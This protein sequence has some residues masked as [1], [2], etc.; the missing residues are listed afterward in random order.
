MKIA[1]IQHNPLIGAFEKNLQTILSWIDK[2]R[3]AG[4][5]LVVLPELT[6]CG[7]PPQDL[8]ERASF[9]ENHDRC[10]TEF[11]QETVDLTC[12]IGV[13][14][15]RMGPGKPLYNSAFV[16]Y[17]GAVLH[18]ARKQLLPTYDVFDET[19]YFEPGRDSL[20]FP[21]QGKLLG[22][23]ICED[24][25]CG[26]PSY[27]VNPLKGFI[28][29]PLVPDLLINISASPYFDGKICQR[30][31][32][33][34]EICGQNTLPLLYVNQVGGQDSLVF[35][36]HSMV[37]NRNGQVSATAAGFA[38]DML[39]VEGEQWSLQES[40]VQPSDSIDHVLE[41][42]TL[43]VRD[44]LY[45]TGFS[46]AVLGLSGGIDSAVT[47]AVAC[48]ALG[49]ENVLCIA[50]PS[51]YTAQA[52]IDDA[53][54]LAENFGCDFKLLPIEEI[55]QAYKKSLDQLFTGLEEDVTEQNIQ[56]RIRGNL[57]M[58]LSNK[59]GSLLLSTGNKSEMAVGYCTLYGDMS[60]GLAVIA[61]VPKMMVYALAQVFNR[62]REMIPER[63]I[64]RAPTAELKPD[65]CDQDDLP[66]YEVLDAVLHQYLEENKSIAA[67]TNRGFDGK[68]VRDIVRRVKLNEHKRKQAPLGIK[69]TTKAFGQGRRYPVVQGFTE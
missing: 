28:D 25:W 56:A 51:P 58:A 2:A 40:R 63:I 57:L 62:E 13:I 30:L 36:G 15:Q 60:G 14:E 46:K 49:P 6:L 20:V 31:D 68:V 53:R 35:D 17:G 32:L 24:I 39:I 61:D 9:I 59:F 65:Q 52:S 29:G 19:R 21:F 55:M 26:H 34:K 66:A 3:Q 48:R 11:I 33:F 44:Y 23:S 10:L 27:Q 41:A 64:T 22:L 8:L 45:K 7:Y 1:L 67:I 5:D 43:G 50:M 69:V 4:C 54:D 12:V 16:T 42:L 18:R 38:E 37:V 47:A